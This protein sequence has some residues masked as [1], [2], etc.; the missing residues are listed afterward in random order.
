[1]S[2]SCDSGKKHPADSTLSP[3]MTTAP[4]CS[5]PL[6]LKMLSK[7]PDVTT[8]SNLVP[9]SKMCDGTSVRTMI[10]NAPTSFFAMF[11]QALTICV[12]LLVRSS[13]E[14]SYS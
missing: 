6:V 4:S 2:T 12:A 13:S 10:I 11:W 8:A 7:S 5:G 3:L 1:M 9:V 14:V